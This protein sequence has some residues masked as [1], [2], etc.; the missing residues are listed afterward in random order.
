[1]EKDKI[2]ILVVDDDNRIR[3]LIKQYLD[4]N[5][6]VVSTAVDSRETKI[7]LEQFRFDLIILDV[8]MPG[9][10]GF[11]LTK[12]IKKKIDIPIILLTAKG[13][14]ENRIKG[15]ELG[16]DDYLGKPFE[17]K[18]LLLRIKNIIKKSKKINLNKIGRIGKAKIDLNK[19][20]IELNNKVS[21]LNIA[22]KKVLIEMMSNP[23]KT[24]TREQIG[25]I[26]KISQERSIDVMITRLRQ[27]IEVDSKNPKYLQTIRGSGYV[28]WIE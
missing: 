19:M 12:E 27:K 2:H 26:S 6:F 15:L 7:K 22:E 13:E 11:E 18:E 4:D 17:P 20:T 10:S 3:E 25:N 8:M 21:K 28:L 9:Q 23:G 16:A 1:M 14:V 24:Y 5:N